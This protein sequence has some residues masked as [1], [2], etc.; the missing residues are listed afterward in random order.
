M[1]MYKEGVKYGT[2]MLMIRIPKDYSVTSNGQDKSRHYAFVFC[3][4]C[5]LLLNQTA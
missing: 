4:F 2:S 5:D 1:Y 3:F